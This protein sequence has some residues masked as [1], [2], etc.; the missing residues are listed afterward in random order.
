QVIRD[1]ELEIS[2]MKTLSAAGGET[3]Y[4]K[5]GEEIEVTF[6]AVTA[7]RLFLRKAQI[8]GELLELESLGNDGY[9]C[10]WKGF[11]DAKVHK[12]SLEAV[13]LDGDVK[14]R[15]ETP[16]E[17]K[18]EI[19]KEVPRVEEF[20]WE[21][22]SED[23]LQIQYHLSDADDALSRAEFQILGENSD[24]LLTEE[25]KAGDQVKKM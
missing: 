17:R 24:R 8:N 3:L 25:T 7:S 23:Q 1:Y 10:R 6:R 4:F 11:S 12:L 2:D 13:W 20:R 16:M 18:V 19:L 15:L 9:R 14:L 21:K 5:K 22:N